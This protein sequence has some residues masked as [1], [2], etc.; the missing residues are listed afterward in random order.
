MVDIL[1]Q[2]VNTFLHA[3]EYLR[4]TLSLDNFAFDTIDSSQGTTYDTVVLALPENLDEWT[5]FLGDVHRIITMLSRSFRTV[6]L[7]RLHGRFTSKSFN[8]NTGPVLKGFTT[9]PREYKWWEFLGVAERG[10]LSP[11]FWRKWLNVAHDLSL[12][13][14]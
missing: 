3:N 13:H 12:I 2:A 9:G 4:Q 8:D 6:A 14:I 5:A 11:G 1:R 7:P 10:V